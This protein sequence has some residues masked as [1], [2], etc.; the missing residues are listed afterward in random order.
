MDYLWRK[1]SKF[2]M[3]S[4]NVNLAHFCNMCKATVLMSVVLT[5]AIIYACN[6]SFFSA[7]NSYCFL[8]VMK[9]LCSNVIVTK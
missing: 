1:H 4:G 5:A 6:Y 2:T 8:T 9:S 3:I 7:V